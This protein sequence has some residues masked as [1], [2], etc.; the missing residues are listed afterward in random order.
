MGRSLDLSCLFDHHPNS[1]WNHTNFTQLLFVCAVAGGASL[2]VAL[3]ARI[4]VP[5]GGYA[6]DV[7]DAFGLLKDLVR[8]AT[9]QTIDPPFQPSSPTL[10][11]PIDPA[12]PQ[13]IQTLEALQRSCLDSS[14]SL[15]SSYAY[16]AFELRIGRV[17]IT[18]IKPLLATVDR[19]REELAWG[20]VRAGV[21]S[22][23]SQ[24]GLYND[25]K[26]NNIDD[27]LSPEELELLAT[28]DDPCRSCACA[29]RDSITVLQHAIGL[30]YGI[31][32]PGNVAQPASRTDPE[33][34]AKNETNDNQPKPRVKRS[35]EVGRQCLFNVHA[36]RTRLLETR[37]ALQNQLDAVV[38]NMNDAHMLRMRPHEDSR[39]GSPVRDGLSD[40]T[41]HHHQLFRKSLYATSLLHVSQIMLFRLRAQS[42][43]S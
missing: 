36:E 16:S 14:L 31:E 8:L 11:V 10:A 3:G 21:H 9:S 24:S 25:N 39:E 28:L 20:V 23:D 27:Q 15:H 6:K 4:F 13:K 5:G 42:N 41:S 29:I 7:I 22:Q 2:V 40:A 19:V 37:A 18:D 43:P 35:T 32:V 26:Q 30:C 38:R 33:A 12:S 34:D 1:K 17:P